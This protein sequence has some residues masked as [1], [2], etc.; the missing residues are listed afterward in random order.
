MKKQ[1]RRPVLQV[2]AIEV[3]AMNVNSVKG[4]GDLKTGGGSNGPA[5]GRQQVDWE[6]EEDY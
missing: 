6:D 1:Y 5:R 2:V 4:N 3:V